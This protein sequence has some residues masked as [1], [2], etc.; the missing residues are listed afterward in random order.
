MCIALIWYIYLRYSRNNDVRGRPFDV[1]G[2]RGMDDLRKN[3]FCRLISGGRKQLGKIY[4]S[5]RLMLENNV[6]GFFLQRFGKNPYPNQITH[7]PSPPL[8][9]SNGWPL[10]IPFATFI[11]G[12]EWMTRKF[13]CP[14][15]SRLA[16]LT[17]SSSWQ[18]DKVGITVM[19]RF[20][21]TRIHLLMTFLLSRHKMSKC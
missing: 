13:P 3:V 14:F 19:K 9:K 16:S 11:R 1:W 18:P 17:I 15:W 2:E 20:E 5:W 6:G 7:T 10:N 21:R 4:L 12:R 8:Q